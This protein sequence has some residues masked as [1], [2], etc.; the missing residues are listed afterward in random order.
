MCHT[1]YRRPG[2]GPGTGIHGRQ[3]SPEPEIWMQS[4]NSGKAPSHQTPSKARKLIR[5]RMFGNF[6]GTGYRS[7]VCHRCP[8][9]CLE[10]LNTATQAT[11]HANSFCTPPGFSSGT[12]WQCAST[13]C[14]E[15]IIML[16]GGYWIIP[17]LLLVACYYCRKKFRLQHYRYRY[18]Y[19]S[20]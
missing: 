5:H 8:G 18:V 17:V 6:H 20:M 19:S 13:T 9:V 12:L 15:V 16:R 1:Q 2:A 11:K 14:M 10:L 4:H 3:T 7:S